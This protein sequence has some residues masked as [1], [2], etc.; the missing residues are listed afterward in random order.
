LIFIR[1]RWLSRYSTSLNFSTISLNLYQG[2]KKSMTYYELSPYSWIDYS[3]VGKKIN[4]RGS[5]L[6]ALRLKP[7]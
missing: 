1:K 3:E 5:G 4:A 2:E 7:V 6:R